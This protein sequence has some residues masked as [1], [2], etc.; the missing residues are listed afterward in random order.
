[1]AQLSLPREDSRLNPCC[2]EIVDTIKLRERPYKHEGFI[3]KVELREG[4]IEGD[5][6]HTLH[7]CGSCGKV[8]GTCPI[9]GNYYGYP[10]CF[11]RLGEKGRGRVLLCR[12]CSTRYMHETLL[13][14]LKHLRR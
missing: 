5:N 6:L 13:R 11:P 4:K 3:F 12:E 14:P 10:I 1:M 2:I 9:C 8:L 7:L